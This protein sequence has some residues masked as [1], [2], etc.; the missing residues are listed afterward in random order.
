V[1]VQALRL[2]LGGADPAAMSRLHQ[3]GHRST[4]LLRSVRDLT[5]RQ[6]QHLTGEILQVRGLMPLLMKPRN[7]QRWTPEEKKELVVHL[8]RLTSISP[9]LVVLAIPGGMLALL[10]LAW[11]VDRRRKRNRTSPAMPH[12]EA[13]SK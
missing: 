10:V 1:V 6:Q 9:Y 2:T 5:R 12:N 3:L 7:N 4:A 8:R 13:E 11:W